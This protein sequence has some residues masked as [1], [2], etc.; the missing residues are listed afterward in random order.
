MAYSDAVEPKTNGPL[1]SRDTLW[2][3]QDICSREELNSTCPWF[4]AAAVYSDDEEVRRV[5]CIES[6]G[7]IERTLRCYC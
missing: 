3:V 7:K 1:L 6:Y 4:R 2:A 5:L